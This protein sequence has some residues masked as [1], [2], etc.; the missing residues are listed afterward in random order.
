VSKSGNCCSAIQLNTLITTVVFTTLGTST[1]ICYRQQQN[2]TRFCRA[3]FFRVWDRLLPEATRATTEI[4]PFS[5]VVAQTVSYCDEDLQQDIQTVWRVAR[6]YPVSGDLIVFKANTKGPTL[7]GFLLV[8][9]QS[10]TTLMPFAIA[11]TKNCCCRWAGV[12]RRHRR[13]SELWGFD[14]TRGT[15]CMYSHVCLV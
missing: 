3:Y 12:V 1:I 7:F 5:T 9:S 4:R 11:K 2:N 14:M 10:M 15:S 8:V 6:R 13:N